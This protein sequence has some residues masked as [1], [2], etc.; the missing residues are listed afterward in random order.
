M[1]R[2]TKKWDA[3]NKIG[4]EL[5][6]N[7][8]PCEYMS[9]SSA[10]QHA[11][12]ERAPMLTKKDIKRVSCVLLSGSKIRSMY[13][14]W[15]WQ[16]VSWKPYGDSGC[17]QTTS[18]HS[19]DTFIQQSHSI[20]FGRLY[21]F[22]GRVDPP[23]TAQAANESMSN[24][25]AKAYSSV[26]NLSQKRV[27]DTQVVPMITN[28]SARQTYTKL[29]QSRAKTVDVCIGKQGQVVPIL[30]TDDLRFLAFDMDSNN[31]PPHVEDI[32]HWF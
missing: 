29:I 7:D 14:R 20:L 31:S 2:T 16:G 13:I 6:T 24:T 21:R 27:F 32:V 5:P 12:C 9:D 23:K 11:L 25:R 18:V 4:L 8:I 26:F 30:L 10:V 15:M 19:I 3:Y 1:V 28:E 22:V 17:T